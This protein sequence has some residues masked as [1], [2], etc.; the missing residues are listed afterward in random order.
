MRE[1][2]SSCFKSVN[3]QVEIVQ[4]QVSIKIMPRLFALMWWF[5]TVVFGLSLAWNYL[6]KCQDR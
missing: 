5:R 3:W 4:L 6:V 2:E 1:T